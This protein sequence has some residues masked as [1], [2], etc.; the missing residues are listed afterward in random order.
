M[1]VCFQYVKYDPGACIKHIKMMTKREAN[2]WSK[3]CDE[4]RELPMDRLMTWRDGRCNR[5]HKTFDQVEDEGYTKEGTYPYQTPETCWSY[6]DKRARQ[7]NARRSSSHNHW[8]KDD[9]NKRRRRW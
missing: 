8:E 6:A 5:R 9:D 4:R 2:H 1:C 3:S 7:S